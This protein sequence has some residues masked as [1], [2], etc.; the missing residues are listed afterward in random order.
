A[1][2][3]GPPAGGEPSAAAGATADSGRN[4]GYYDSNGVWQSGKGD[5]RVTDSRS[6]DNRASGYYDSNGV[7]Q[8]GS[9]TSDRPDPHATFRGPPAGGDAMAQNR[10]AAGYYDSNGVWHSAQKDSA[11]AVASNREG[12]YDSNGVWQPGRRDTRVTTGGGWY[13]EKGVWR[14]DA[15]ASMRT[16]NRPDAHATFRGPPA[17]GGAVTD[18]PMSSDGVRVVDGNPN[19]STGYYDSNGVWHSVGPAGVVNIPIG[20]STSRVYGPAI[21][22]TNRSWQD[23]SGYAAS[24]TGYYDS[25][26]VWQTRT[27][28][29]R[30]YA[31]VNTNRNGYQQPKD[32]MDRN[33]YA[34]ENRGNALAVNWGGKP[35]EQV[36]MMTGKYGQPDEVTDS[37]VAWKDKGG[38]ACIK[39]FK[40]EVDHKWP[41]AHTDF[42]EHAVAYK[43]PVDKVGELA[44]FDGSVYV[45]VTKGC[46]AA[47]CDKESHNLL[48]LN[49]AND[50][51]TGKKTATE[52]RDYFARAIAD[53]MAGKSDPYLERLA[54]TPASAGTAGNP[55]A[56]H[57]KGSV[58]ESMKDAEQTKAER[59]AAERDAKNRAND[60]DRDRMNQDQNR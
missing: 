46:L 20:T 7:W 50:I 52:A 14:S 35:G 3:R 37:C 5:A 36:R 4:T 26:G 2:F 28:D 33:G 59:E 12:S 17:G 22:Q 51:C 44:K 41:V 53:E 30:S 29:D 45:D 15:Q 42:L 24:D 11:T 34:A 6:A 57:E 18:T 23:R 27:R 39:V 10:T 25:N 56:K 8:S 40:E 13:D 31:Q 32:A 16:D 48:A 60:A 43:V 19:V 47:K 54:F 1:T 38:F 58:N 9:T 55:G 21:V 49:L